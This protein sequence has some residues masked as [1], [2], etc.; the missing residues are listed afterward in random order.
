MS[1]STI[2]ARLASLIGTATGSSNVHGEAMTIDSEAAAVTLLGDGTDTEGRALLIGWWVAPGKSDARP[3]TA[4]N[5]ISEHR[6]TFEV[7]G[8]RSQAEGQ[9]AL[10]E[11]DL[12]AVKA[13]LLAFTALA[14]TSPRSWVESVADQLG[15]ARL[16]GF[17]V[18]ET[19]LTVVVSEYN[20]T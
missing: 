18:W 9:E 7:L 10:A 8:Y 1:E 11:A 5:G 12:E 20:S 3:L 2:R 15:L 19:R 17:L 4:L 14:G 16:A 6:Y 13:A